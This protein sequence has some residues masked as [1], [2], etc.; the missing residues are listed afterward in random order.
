MMH[1]TL[2]FSLG[3]VAGTALTY[4]P[5]LDAWRRRAALAPHLRRWLIMAYGLGVFAIVPNLLRRAGVPHELCEAWFM[6]IFLFSS[7]LN[8]SIQG[9]TIY[10]PFVMG[11]FVVS[12]YLTLLWA[13]ARTRSSR[14]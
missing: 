10:G 11:L 12:Q 7:L 1:S 6:N 8:S 4:R 9:G 14:A 5:L 2:H 3:M 13:L